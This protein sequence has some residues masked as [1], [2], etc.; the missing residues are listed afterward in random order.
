MPIV[1][2]LRRMVEPSMN[3][4]TIGV[5]RRRMSQVEGL[6]TDFLQFLTGTGHL[7]HYFILLFPVH[8]A[9]P[10]CVTPRTFD[11]QN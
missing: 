10:A 6:T 9:A 5:G 11:L 3:A 4:K 7:G 1:D 2:V 8:L